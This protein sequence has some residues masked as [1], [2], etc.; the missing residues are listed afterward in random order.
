MR[1]IEIADDAFLPDD[2]Y[3]HLAPGHRKIVR[4]APRKHAAG[5]SRPSGHI[6]ALTLKSDIAY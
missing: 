5:D 4:L 6:V 2:N 1:F 3:F